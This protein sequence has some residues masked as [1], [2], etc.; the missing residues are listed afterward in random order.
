[1]ISKEEIPV[2]PF[3]DGI[4]YSHFSHEWFATFKE[5]IIFTST[6]EY[7]VFFYNSNLSLIDSLSRDFGNE[8]KKS[9]K[10]HKLSDDIKGSLQS[11]HEV[12]DKISR[13][14]KIYSDGNNKLYVFYK[15]NGD[16]EN[17]L[18]DVWHYNG[19]W[20]LIKD[21]VPMNYVKGNSC[22][23]FKN[24][25][26]IGFSGSFLYYIDP[27]KKSDASEFQLGIQKILYEF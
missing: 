11:F 4:Q 18:M 19:K 9:M 23:H 26:S 5:Q 2:F 14:L 15:F 27:T 13:V 7:K 25:S 16:F 24:T 6:T 1:M 17:L 8:W 20:M 21:K 22:Y 10:K 12:D 3:F